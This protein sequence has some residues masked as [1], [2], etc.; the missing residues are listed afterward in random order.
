M[1][2]SYPICLEKS[3]AAKNYVEVCSH[4]YLFS[5]Q[6]PSIWQVFWWGHFLSRSVT[7][8]HWSRQLWA[9]RGFTI[10]F[11]QRNQWIYCLQFILDV[12]IDGFFG[13][14]QQNENNN[15]KNT[16]V[17]GL[18]RPWSRNGKCVRLSNFVC[19]LSSEDPPLQFT[20]FFGLTF[21]ISKA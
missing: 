5:I 16:N 1:I 18:A 21:F 12:E 17:L 20:N 8:S 19:I 15:V 6:T 2:S 10:Y 14:H 4:F 13:L 9:K 7:A 11:R 3:K